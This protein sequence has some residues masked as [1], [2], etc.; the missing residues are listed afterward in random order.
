MTCC[1]YWRDILTNPRPATAVWKKKKKHEINRYTVTFRCNQIDLSGG[2]GLH[3]DH[4]GEHV[5]KRTRRSLIARSELAHGQPGQVYRYRRRRR[6]RHKLRY[7]ISRTRWSKT[8]LENVIT[9]N[10][11]SVGK[12]WSRAKKTMIDPVA[13]VRSEKKPDE[14]PIFLALTRYEVFRCSWFQCPFQLCF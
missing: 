3:V 7:F 10:R 13:R 14:C 6:R 5:G 2:P 11:T 12:S 8:A 1:N 4:R 9:S